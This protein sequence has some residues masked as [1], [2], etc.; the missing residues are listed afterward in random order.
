MCAMGSCSGM[1]RAMEVLHNCVYCRYQAKGRTDSGACICNGGQDY[2]FASSCATCGEIDFHAEP[3]DNG[4]SYRH[5]GV[6]DCVCGL[7][8][9]YGKD[10]FDT[11]YG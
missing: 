11:N 1:G 8:S 2:C 10:C 9:F 6:G 4:R 5:S 3:V 7:P